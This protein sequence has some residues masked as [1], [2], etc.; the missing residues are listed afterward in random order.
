MISH[1]LTKLLVERGIVYLSKK[2]IL[3]PRGSLRN[4]D[5][6]AT[7]TMMRGCGFSFITKCRISP[8][9]SKMTSKEMK[10]EA[11]F[12]YII[13]MPTS[14]P[15]KFSFPINYIRSQPRKSAH[16]DHIPVKLVQKYDVHFS[17]ILF[18]IFLSLFFFS[19]CECNI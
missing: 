6:M 9:L 4:Y 14:H 3:R 7:E 2:K 17:S 13:F 8:K 5:G 1:L 15:R 12:L 16:T 18:I 19:H 11:S 10:M